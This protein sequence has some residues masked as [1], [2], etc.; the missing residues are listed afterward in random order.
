MYGGNSH[1]AQ[2]PKSRALTKVIDLIIEIQSFERQFVIIKGLLQSELPKQHMVTIGL[3]QSLSNS[4][5]YEYR[6]LK[7]IK[8]LYKCSEKCDDQKQYKEIIESEMVSTTKVF[9]DN[10]SMLPRE[11]VT[12]KRPSTR[13]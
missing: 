7:N 11:Y 5:M 13:K 8:K 4:A 12:F 2:Y 10:S 9:T 1:A 6:F 3:D